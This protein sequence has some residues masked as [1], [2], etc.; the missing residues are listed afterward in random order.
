[1]D[2]SVIII[3]IYVISCIGGMN[4]CDIRLFFCIESINSIFITCMVN[5]VF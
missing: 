2:K 1:M 4:W 5:Y 3:H